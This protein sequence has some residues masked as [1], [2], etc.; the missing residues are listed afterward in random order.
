[1]PDYLNFS[2]L[3]QWREKMP[4]QAT[5][6][7]ATLSE[8]PP[9]LFL[10]RISRSPANLVDRLGFIWQSR[11][12]TLAS[13]EDFSQSNSWLRGKPSVPRSTKSRPIGHQSQSKPNLENRTMLPR[14]SFSVSHSHADFSRTDKGTMELG[15]RVLSSTNPLI[16]AMKDL[17]PSKVA[18]KV[19]HDPCLPFLLIVIAKESETLCEFVLEEQFS[20]TVIR[21][22]CSQVDPNSFCQL[23]LLAVQTILKRPLNGQRPR[24]EEYICS[25]WR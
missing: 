3:A 16:A 4:S 12:S 22:R 11:V 15:P 10:A 23:S 9:S 21:R 7:L 24:P 25:S 1:M 8:A 20:H 18:I 19:G 17:S 13:S 14:T 6:I 5:H 2:C